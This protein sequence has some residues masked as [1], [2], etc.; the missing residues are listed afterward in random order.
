MLEAGLRQ[1]LGSLTFWY[2]H[3]VQGHK[4]DARDDTSLTHSL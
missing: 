3:F 2:F 1:S 4:L